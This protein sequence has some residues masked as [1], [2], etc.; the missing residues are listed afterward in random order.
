VPTTSK[1]V[2][3]SKNAQIMLKILRKVVLKGTGKKA[4]ID[5]IFTAGKTGTAQ[6]NINGK[7]QNIYNSSFFG[8]ANDKKH[9]Y[10]IGVTFLRIRAKWPNYFASNSAVPTFKKIVDIMI[11]NNLL[12]E[13]NASELFD[14]TY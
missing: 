9:K 3:T 13:I 1:R 14:T 11:K 10:T 8:F 4:L 7:Y 12:K 6:V 5:G 2:I